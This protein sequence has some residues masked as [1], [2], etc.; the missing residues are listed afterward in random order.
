MTVPI[1]ASG[2]ANGGG[3][4]GGGAGGSWSGIDVSIIGGTLLPRLELPTCTIAFFFE[5]FLGAIVGAGGGGGG[6]GRDGGI[7][8][9]GAETAGP[10]GLRDGERDLPF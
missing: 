3:S 9:S 6:G 5:A 10:V 2:G 1:S 8:I 4:G 7:G